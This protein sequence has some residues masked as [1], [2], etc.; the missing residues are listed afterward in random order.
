MGRSR[1]FLD[2]DEAVGRNL[3]NEPRLRAGDLERGL[4]EADVVVEAEYRTQVLHNSMEPHQAVCQWEGD[5]LDVYISTQFIWGVRDDVAESSD[6]RRTT[7]AWSATSWAAASARRTAP[8]TTR[9]SRPS[10]RSGPAGRCAAPHA[11]RGEPRRRQPQRDDP[12]PQA[13]AP[14]RRHAAALAGDF[15]N[16]VGWDGWLATT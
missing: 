6:W 13:P 10:S 8:A 16:A 11:A 5:T 1:A 12:A 7:C 9:S 2:P 15:V 4:A 3:L 14:A